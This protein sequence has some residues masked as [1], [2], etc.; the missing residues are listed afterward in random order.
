MKTAIEKHVFEEM[1]FDLDHDPGAGRNVAYHCPEVLA[2]L[3]GAHASWESRL[4]G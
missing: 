2:E 3:H 4:H 1:L